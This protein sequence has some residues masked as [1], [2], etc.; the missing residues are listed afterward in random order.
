[1]DIW[2]C[3]TITIDV[4]EGTKLEE[5]VEKLNE[6]RWNTSNL[7]VPQNISLCFGEFTKTE[8]DNHWRDR[9]NGGE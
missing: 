5:L 8:L 7:V 1:M 3:K 4:P 9:Q 6:I 2:S